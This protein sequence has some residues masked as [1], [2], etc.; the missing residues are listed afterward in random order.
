MMSKN[1]LC[2][3]LYS[4]KLKTVLYVMMLFMGLIFLAIQ[5]YTVTYYSTIITDSDA[6]LKS[7]VI[8]ELA[9]E[10]LIHQHYP[11]AVEL[12][13]EI[14]DDPFFQNMFTTEDSQ[15]INRQLSRVVSEMTSLKG[16]LGIIEMR[17]LSMDYQQMGMWHSPVKESI[18][19]PEFLKQQRKI[20]DR[21]RFKITSQFIE[22]EEGNPVHVLV[23]PFGP[24]KVQGF[25]VLIT[26]PLASLGGMGE[27]ISADVEV[28]NLL[29]RTLI[30][31][32][33][34]LSASSTT[35]DFTTLE[36]PISLNGGKPFLNVV[37]RYDNG[38]VLNQQ[39]RV[40]IFSVMVVIIGFLVSL[41][42]VSYVLNISM[43]S[44][45]WEISETLS[46]ILQGKAG[47]K[48]HEARN[49]ELSG[50]WEQ[51]EKIAA[52]EEDRSRLSYEL[53]FALR[54][55][56]VSNLAKSEFLT[57]MSHELRT[58]LNAIIGF[59]ELMTCDYMANDLN[60]KFRE[61]AHDIRNS[62]IHLLSIINDM[63]DL[64]KIEAGNMVLAVE[65]VAVCDIIGK[66]VKQIAE[67]ATKKSISIENK[68]SDKLPKLN[69]DKRM[70]HQVLDNILSNAVKFTPEGG[71]IIVD[72]GLEEDGTF[73]I[74]VSDDG[75]G[76]EE[77]QIGKII[78][79]FSQVDASYTREQEGTGLGLALVKALME[80]HGGQMCLESTWGVGTSVYLVFPGDCLIRETGKEYDNERNVLLVNQAI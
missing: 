44:K 51:L 42:I 67:P 47:V 62:G 11:K 9:R 53:V 34:D 61:Y 20:R 56:E 55:A 5:H 70:I 6:R 39:G 76:I 75:I 8:K 74:A 2:R 16:D 17:V 78:S 12:A 69:V 59:S 68:I 63:L 50:L 1:T 36:I 45:I 72:A 29:G 19:I 33:S 49:D 23:F 4:V 60:D 18:T 25:L 32:N 26:S 21:D 13:E 38:A 77:D 41:Y 22:S 28:H 66:A 58:P 54:E 15:A 3:L 80:L 65:E 46:K 31:G 10:R 52:N 71:H 40:N 30:A 24:V 64:S 57:N 79:P 7:S 35:L 43:L 37:V 14:T 27:F 48:L 73:C